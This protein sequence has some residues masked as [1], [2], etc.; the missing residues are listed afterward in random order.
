M[1]EMMVHT[2]CVRPQNRRK[3]GHSNVRVGFTRA[4]LGPKKSWRGGLAS[5]TTRA[6]RK[7]L[8]QAHPP[9][10]FLLLPTMMNVRWHQAYDPPRS[11]SACALAEDQAGSW[12]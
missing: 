6:I 12:R 2:S 5:P 10:D 1:F 7:S 4:S 3:A 11:S 9:P 8:L